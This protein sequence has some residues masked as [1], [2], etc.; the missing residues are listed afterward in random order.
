MA[1]IRK[2]NGRYQAQVGIGSASKLASILLEAEARL[3][4]RIR[5]RSLFIVEG[6]WQVYADG[7]GQRGCG[8][9]EC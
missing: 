4:S 5:G 2:R 3:G 6:V 1:S 9:K 8:A 7:Y